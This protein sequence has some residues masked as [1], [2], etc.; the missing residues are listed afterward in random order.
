MCLVFF[1]FFFCDG[2]VVVVVFVKIQ[3]LERYPFIFEL[4]AGG[5]LGVSELGGVGM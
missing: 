5:V 2:C 1:C 4:A 3:K